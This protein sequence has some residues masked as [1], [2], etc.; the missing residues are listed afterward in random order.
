ATPHRGAALAEKIRL[1]PASRGMRAGSRFLSELDEA[2]RR[3]ERPREVVPYAVTNDTWV[4]ATRTAPPGG[5]VLWTGGSRVLSHFTVSVNR[6]IVT[7]IAL[8]LRGEAPLAERGGVP[9]RD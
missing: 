2:W 8:R 7:D 1:D 6:A 4:G 5:R 3:G 9:P